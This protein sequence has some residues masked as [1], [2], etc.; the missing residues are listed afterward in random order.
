MTL[1]GGLSVL[2][3]G[4]LLGGIVVWALHRPDAA[5]SDTPDIGAKVELVLGTGGQQ[6]GSPPPA[7]EAPPAEKPSPPPTPKPTPPEPKPEP[8]APDPPVQ[9][10]PPPPPDPQAAPAPQPAPPA[11]PAPEPAPKPAAPPVPPPAPPAPKAAPEAPPAPPPSRAA[12]PAVRLGD[13]IAAPPAELRGPLDD[14]AA[15]PDATNTAPEYPM[16]AARR[17]E[18]GAVVLTL[19]VDASGGVVR[20]DIIQ[21]SGSPR[22]DAAARTKLLTWHF[23]PAIKDGQPVPSVVQQVVDFT[24]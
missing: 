13:G 17:R 2:A 24:F 7:A 16:E 15:G 23:H 9:A 14:I 11:E 18:T 19:H 6:T 4:L 21:S 8:V 10:P 20:A 12:P 5:V 3:H 1:A 22:L